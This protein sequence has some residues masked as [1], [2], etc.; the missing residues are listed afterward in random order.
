M[1]GAG[2]S[3]Q[4]SSALSLI[5]ILSTDRNPLN[6]LPSNY[7][8]NIKRDPG[9]TLE[10][11]FLTLCMMWLHLNKSE[12][13]CIDKYKVSNCSL[14]HGFLCDYKLYIH[15]LRGMAS[16]EVFAACD[17]STAKNTDLPWFFRDEVV[18]QNL[19][20]NRMDFRILA[21]QIVRREVNHCGYR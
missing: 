20:E 7:K 4:K 16:E 13:N 9:G 15:E 19:I 17:P 21:T 1:V 10:Y 5:S 11:E 12:K 2:T 6:Y 18:S 14:R 8:W 3:I